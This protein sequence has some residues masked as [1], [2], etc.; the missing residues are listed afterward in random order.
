MGGGWLPSRRSFV[1][2]DRAVSRRSKAALSALRLTHVGDCAVDQPSRLSLIVVM[3]VAGAG[4]TTV[5]QLLARE[6]GWTF[7][8]A[9]DYHSPENRA[10]LA[11]GVEL[12]DQ[13]RA[14]WLRDLNRGVLDHIARAE[15]VVLAC[16]ALKE[17]Y[18]AVLTDSIAGSRFVY[19]KVTPD[20]IKARL[21][22]RAHFFD[23]SLQA[24]QF[25]TLEE[26]ADALVVD[27]SLPALEIATEIRRELFGQG[28]RIA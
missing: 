23:P 11:A 19:L 2:N 28:G 3:G 16:S 24:S 18:R 12:T 17:P 27:G 9:D 14:A 10:K 20:L 8:D 25:A 1:K 4:K 21:S 5:G 13:D 6:I 26:P 7:I 15:R 22:S